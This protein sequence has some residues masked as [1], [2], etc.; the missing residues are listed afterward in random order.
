MRA[1]LDDGVAGLVDL[2]PIH[3]HLSGQNQRAGFFTRGDEPALD[4]QL[5]E[6]QRRS[7]GLAVHDPVGESRAAVRRAR[8][9][10]RKAR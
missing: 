2:L 1:S 4:E 3:A 9:S 8:P 6:S 5:V 7:L 10:G